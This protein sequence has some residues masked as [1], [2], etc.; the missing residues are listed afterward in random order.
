MVYMLF[1]LRISQHITVRSY[2]CAAKKTCER[3]GTS[4]NNRK[5]QIQEFGWS[6]KVLKIIL[7]IPPAPFT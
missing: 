4:T 2:Y 1:Y 7:C 5:Q 6:G 3:G